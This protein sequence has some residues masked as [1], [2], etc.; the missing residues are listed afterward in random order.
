[1]PR[2]ARRGEHRA[3]SPAGAAPLEGR[4][5]VRVAAY[6]QHPD[7]PDLTIDVMKLQAEDPLRVLPAY[8]LPDWLKRDTWSRREALLLLAGYNPNV[9]Q[10]TETSNGFDQFPAGNNVGYLD[11]LTEK[12]IRH[13]NVAWR[14]P[15]HDEAYEQFLILSDYARG[16]SL[17]ERRTPSAWIEWAA[18][19]NFAP[20]W[21]GAL[22]KTQGA[23]Q[24]EVLSIAS[25][26]HAEMRDLVPKGTF[27]VPA[28]L[29]GAEQVAEIN[30][31][32]REFW[33]DEK[34]QLQSNLIQ[35]AQELQ[36]EHAA[37][38]ARAKKAA[39]DRHSQPGGTR[40]KQDKIRQEWASGRYASRE[41]CARQKCESLG[42]SFSAARKALRNT[43]EPT[44]DT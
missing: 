9:T 8:L 28:E 17:E 11:M 20:Y 23:N 12:I 13:A 40:D 15:R 18:S 16:G 42:M 27:S 44:R 21:I 30:R 19:K 1:M 32:N 4:R 25:V 24:D 31:K 38:K 34:N 37:K 29:R 39:D 14:H 36:A 3:P 33:A 6:V 10:W 22:P 35:V 7:N 41:I 2:L 5:G 43:P 26:I